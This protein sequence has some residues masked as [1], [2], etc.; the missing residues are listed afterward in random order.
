LAE[1]GARGH[2]HSAKQATHGWITN[3][4]NA[5]QPDDKPGP[6]QKERRLSV[7]ASGSGIAET[8]ASRHRRRHPRDV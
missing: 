5:V 7:A 8:N 1:V 4:V 3:S 6:F 2:H